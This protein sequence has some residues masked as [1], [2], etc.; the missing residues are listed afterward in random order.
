[1]NRRLNRSL[2]IAM[3]L[4]V[5]AMALGACTFIANLAP[6]AT[7]QPTNTP[8]PPATPTRMP[9]TPDPSLGIG[10][11]RIFDKDGM[12]L[13]YIPAGEFVM[14]SNDGPDNEKPQHTV[15]LD[16]F[17]IDQTEV[18]NAMY[19]KCVKAEA[20]RTPVHTSSQTRA[21][22]YGNPQFDNYPV[23]Y[24]NWYYARK[25]CTWVDGDLPTEAQWEKAA[26]GTDGRLYPWG[27]QTPDKTRLNY[28]SA[29]GDTTQVGLYP[30]G[31]SP[32]GTLDMAGNVREWV[33]D[34]YSEKYYDSSPE[35]NPIGPTQ[36]RAGSVSVRVLVLR[37]V[38]WYDVASF[39]RAS[40]RDWSGNGNQSVYIGFRCVR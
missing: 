8:A 31:A 28:N 25:Y 6:T 21:S 7:L 36:E 4:I 18:T 10:S 38:S 3:L 33:R 5:L 22:Y 13:L 39:V 2:I 35:R 17:W 34:W 12:T 9:P 19:A 24:V 14:G 30:T 1:M 23:V 40:Y 27:N 29:I 32:Y 16:A 20:C 11:K 37:G 26:R 15:Y